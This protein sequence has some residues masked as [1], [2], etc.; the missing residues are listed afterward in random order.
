MSVIP[1]QVNPARPEGS[2]LGGK[3][4]IQSVLEN[5]PGFRIALCAAGMTAEKFIAFVNLQNP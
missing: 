4:G 5:P 2:P 1:M 3:A